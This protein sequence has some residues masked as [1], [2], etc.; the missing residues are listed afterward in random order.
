MFKIAPIDQPT[1]LLMK[2][3]RRMW[4]WAQSTSEHTNGSSP[5]KTNRRADL[6]VR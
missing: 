5:L 2:G 1:D 6:Y 4:K 3:W